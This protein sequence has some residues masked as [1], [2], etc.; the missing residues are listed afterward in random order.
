M[1]VDI[2]GRWDGKYGFDSMF[3]SSILYSPET[4]SLSYYDVMVWK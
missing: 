2:Q 3:G 1:I 4:D